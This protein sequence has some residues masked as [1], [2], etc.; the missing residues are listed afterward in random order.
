MKLGIKYRIMLHREISAYREISAIIIIS[1]QTT[2]TCDMSQ[3][4]AFTFYFISS[5][6]GS[7]YQFLVGVKVGNS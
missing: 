3:L 4:F 1:S 7:S 2:D 5:I 6:C